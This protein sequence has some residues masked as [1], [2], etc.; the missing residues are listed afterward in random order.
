MIKTLYSEINYGDMVEL[1]Y[2]TN[3]KNYINDF[4]DNLTPE[5][6]FA[7]N[8][9]VSRFTTTIEELT[10]KADIIDAAEV[11]S[12]LLSCATDNAKELILA[13]INATTDFAD[14]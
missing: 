14:A 2:D 6:K 10:E 13:K 8:N 9:E 1:F 7:L 3:K 11:I 4:L 12:Q 5:Q